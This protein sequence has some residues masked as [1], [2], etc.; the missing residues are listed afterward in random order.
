[1][2]TQTENNQV[3]VIT[4][5]LDLLKTGPQILV[6]NQERKEKALSVGRNILG[7]IQDEGMSP[8]TDERA[9]KYLANINKAKTEMKDSRAAVTQIMDKLKTMYTE[10][11]NDLDVNK[12][13]TIP[14]QIQEHRNQYA[15]DLAAAAE[16]K[17]KDA[18]RATAKA[19]EAIEIKSSIEVQLSKAYNDYL[20]HMKQ[21]LQTHFNSITLEDYN[22]NSAKLKS[23]VPCLNKEKFSDLKAAV[24]ALVHTPEEIN[25]FIK[26]VIADKT[27]EY[28]TNYA[29]ELS[30][31]RDELIDKLPSKLSE[32]KEQK[33]LA[34]EAAAEAERQR[35]EK[36]KLDAEIAQANAAKKKKLEE[37]AEKVRI[38]NEKK[39]AE[40]KK[41]QEEAAAAQKLREEQETQ[42]LNAE[43]EESQ[44]KSVL[45]AEVKKQGEQTMVLFD[46][47]A[48]LAESAPAPEAR[49][50]YEITI[51]HPIGF[52]QI[53]AIWFENV[54]KD[55]PVDKIG[56]TSLDQMKAWAEK[57]AQKTESKIDSKLLKYEPVFR[58]INKS[59]KNH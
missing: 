25:R 3:A 44:R 10:V 17:R 54:G 57:H 16:Q 23:Y 49:Q 32:L 8:T 21:K 27:P 7:S 58:A 29:A 37:E 5:S 13:G 6:A 15:K 30:L 2:E 55:L 35:I 38:E 28:I 4:K 22:E 19:R 31:L 42:R 1:M 51:L 59:A 26:S 34:D 12:S 56:R 11:E 52:T 53:F 20:L 33:R 50:G 24:Y 45:N 48:T 14:A 41:Q 40:L 47:E 46:Q 43:A 39:N 9:M 36:E 18:E